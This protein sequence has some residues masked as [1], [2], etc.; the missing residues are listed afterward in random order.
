MLIIK[1]G[2]D[3]TFRTGTINLTPLADD[4]GKSILDLGVFGC[5]S[6]DYCST[7]SDYYCVV[8]IKSMDKKT[9]VNLE[10]N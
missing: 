3:G 7:D 10:N 4:D 9:L 1:I 2:T 8:A 6:N 5:D